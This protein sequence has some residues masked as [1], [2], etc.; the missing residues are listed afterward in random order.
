MIQ[1]QM[2]NYL[3]KTGD[4]SIIVLN[5]LDKTFFSDY[6]EHFDFINNHLNTYGKI[7]DQITFLSR[8][9]DFDIVEVN[10]SSKYLLDELYNDKNMRSLAKTFNQIKDLLN[11]KKVDEA[12]SLYMKASEEMTLGIHLDSVDILRDTSRYDAYIE[13]SEDFA[14][15][16]VKTGFK[17]LDEIIGGWDRQEELA[18][19]IARPNVGKCLEKGTKVLMAD[20]TIKNIEDIIVGDKVQSEISA[21]NVI[22]L[23]NG[24]SVGYKIIPKVGDSFVVS[25]GHILTLMRRNHVLRKG[26]T[27]HTTDRTFTLVDMPIEDYLAMTPNQQAMYMLY[28]PGISY[29]AKNLAI[30]PYILGCWLGDGTSCRVALT[31][32]DSSIIEEWQNYAKN[33]NL[34]AHMYP[35][36][37]ASK[38]ATFEITGKK[39]N[40]NSVLEAFRSYNLISNK[41]IPLDYLTSSIEQRLELLAGILDT[42]GYLSSKDCGT[43][44]L[45]LKSKLLIEQTAQLARGLDFRVGKIKTRSL[46]LLKKGKTNYYTINISGDLTRIPNRLDRKKSVRN[47]SDRKLSLT[48][49]TV[50]TV[51]E[52]EYFGFECDGDH[53]FLLADNTLT[54]NSWVLL[55]VAA[56]AA[57]QGLNVGFYSGEMSERKVGYRID[58]LLGKISN[59]KLI[60]GNRDIQNEYKRFLDGLSEEIPGK[61]KVLTPT[62][63]GG[64]AGVTALRAFI[65]KEKLDML[66]IDQHS[67][68]E[69]DRHAKDPVTKASN[70]SRDLKNLQVLKKIPIIAVSQGNRSINETG[71]LGLQ[72]IA[73]S[74]RI[75]QDSTVVLGLDQKDGVLSV[76]LLKS[77]DS[78]NGKI[79]KY[80]V[81]FD[82][83]TLVY[84]PSEDDAAG[85]RYCED[86]NNRYEES[87]DIGEDEF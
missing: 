17:E 19:I 46:N 1:L 48:N 30:P 18:T 64:A 80:N 79:L 33:N 47:D 35:Q 12:M 81:N 14:K 60:H 16:Y 55:N 53:R 76:H 9:S 15:Y 83:G 44:S 45:C 6:Q 74:D 24:N 67:L 20:G 39:G 78:A 43:F 4:S 37:T 72:N 56:A 77:R 7:P 2:L 10:E 26:N 54:H 23:H 29:E 36:K 42:D 87:H 71:Q 66:C 59:T 61:I 11:D 41:H 57:K 28:R 13:R 25:A 85:G 32:M 65:E 68:L 73:Q 82:K 3:L 5:N 21:N 38:A 58:T 69:D 40:K 51:P 52:I 63:I 75:G 62:M 70:I 8:F 27:L 49:F 86:L 34:N 50:E 22:A 84:I 31:S